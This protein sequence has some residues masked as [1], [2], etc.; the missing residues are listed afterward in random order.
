[1]KTL[2]GALAVLLF[3]ISALAE[4]G[5]SYVAGNDDMQMSGKHG[6][7]QRIKNK[8][9]QDVFVILGKG[10]NTRTKQ[11]DLEKWY[12]RAADCARQQGKLVTL[13]IDGEYKYEN[14]FV[15]GAGTIASGMAE[16][17]CGIDAAVK[18]NNNKKGV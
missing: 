9:G 17:I 8:A 2:I 16:F 11:V 18:Q 3:S 14:D 12:V 4:D 10:V 13:T 7:F 1:M 15:F 5:W 6:S